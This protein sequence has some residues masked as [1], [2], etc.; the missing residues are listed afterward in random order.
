M[1]YQTYWTLWALS[2]II[3]I[4]SKATFQNFE[5]YLK[6]IGFWQFDTLIRSILHGSALQVFWVV[7]NK[8][9]YKGI[10]GSFSLPGSLARHSTTMIRSCFRYVLIFLILLLWLS[11]FG[12]QESLHLFNFKFWHYLIQYNFT[13]ICV[14]I[15]MLKLCHFKSYGL[16]ESIPKWKHCNLSES[17]S[18]WLHYYIK[19]SSIYLRV[20]ILGMID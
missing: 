6:H 16:K 17:C 13:N 15:W 9:W 19:K 18:L 2:E 8:Y 20:L 5:W 10:L 3:K 12:F 1:T 7:L 11:L 14:N 4:S